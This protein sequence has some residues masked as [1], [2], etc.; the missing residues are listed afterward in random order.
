[1]AADGALEV[2]APGRERR[3]E[4]QCRERDADLHRP[5]VVQD[6]RAH[7][8]QTVPALVETAATL[9]QPVAQQARRIGLEEIAG[10]VVVEGADDPHEAVVGAQPGIALQLIGQD[11]LGVGVEEHGADVERFVVIEH[12]N[13]GGLAGFPALHRL[14][15]AELGDRPGLGP[16][17]V[18]QG[19]VQ[20]HG[21]TGR[22][23]GG[24]QG[25]AH[26]GGG[27]G[28]GVLGQ[29]GRAK[30]GGGQ[31]QGAAAARR[32]RED[33]GQPRGVLGV[34]EDPPGGPRTDT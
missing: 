33:H 10:A 17:R 8:P 32:T 9:D 5:A 29:S 23:A 34:G 1:M 3:V 12:A 19:A 25:G 31:Q 28:D 22:D 2:D 16:D 6:A 18:I 24:L 13:L 27:G 15:L 21:T 4:V 20:L 30:Q 26:F 14:L 7:V 11:A